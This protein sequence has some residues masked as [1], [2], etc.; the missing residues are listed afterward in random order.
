MKSKLLLAVGI[1]AIGLAGWAVGQEVTATTDDTT[2][3]P[4][5]PPMRHP[6]NPL[7]IA[8]DADKDG[9]LSAQE[10]T[11][12]SVTLLTLDENGDGQLTR[13][14]LRPP[15]PLPPG[16]EKPGNPIMRL[17]T[18]GDGLVSLAEF[19]A[20]SQEMFKKIDTNG[21]GSISADEA[22]AAPPPPM[23]PRGPGGR[24]GPGGPD[25]GGCGKGKGNVGTEK[26]AVQGSGRGARR[27]R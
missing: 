19:S 1:A 15:P 2:A 3:A 24:G 17:D 5:P 22:A 8:L 16:D 6:P 21:D 9:V 13:D 25:G 10:I 18:D 4:P 14:E 26:P 11:N 20:K 27:G 7:I 23:G 12:A